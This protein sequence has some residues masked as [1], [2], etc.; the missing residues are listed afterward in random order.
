VQAPATLRPMPPCVALYCRLSPRPD[1]SYEGVDVQERAGRAYAAKAWPDLPV[2]VFADAGIS[3]ASGDRRPEYDRLRAWVEA[4]SVARLWCVEQSRLERRE[5]EWFQLAALLDAAGVTEVHTDRDGV[6]R[7]RDEVAGIKA[8]L[9]A[10]EVRKLRRRVN[11]R[12]DALAAEGRPPGA[13]VFGYRHGLDDAGRKTLHVVDD[14]AAA[15]RWAA[16]KVLT[17]WSLANV[18]RELTARGHRGAQGAKLTPGAV[19]KIITNPTAAGYRVHRGQIVGRGVWPAILDDETW[20]AVRTRLDR[21]RTVDRSDGGLHRVGPAS[22]SSRAAQKYIL[23]GGLTRCGVCGAAMVG[24]VKQYKSGT[25]PVRRPYLLCPRPD[26]GGRSCTGVM[27][28]P[29]EGH[30]VDALFDALDRPEFLAALAADD[31]ADERRRVV[32]DLEALE[33]QRADLAALWATPGGLTM[34]E[35]QAARDA[36][37]GHEQALRRRLAAV[38]PAVVT[39]DIAGAREAWPA[40]TLDER[41]EFVRLFVGRV[42]VHRARPGA[43]AFDPGRLTVEWRQR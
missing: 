8:V 17:G 11:D 14:Q 5:V 18:A 32:D 13:T 40:M 9:A 19:R 24:T 27:L 28:E 10:G 31:Y 12:L 35:W 20:Q 39:L 36:L 2:E 41:R 30:V 21:P 26:L 37:A 43:R 3:A 6:V 7:V 34:A 15:L 4:G 22:L 38:P 33:R 23:T 29:T 16:E 1:G 42:V 25:R